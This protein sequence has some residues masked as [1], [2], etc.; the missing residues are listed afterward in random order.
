LSHREYEVEL[1]EGAQE[2]LRLRITTES[3]RV[4][5]FTVQYETTI[6]GKRIAIARFDTAHGRPHFDLL[7][8]RGRVIAKRWLPEHVGYNEALEM[9]RADLLANWRRYHRA[10]MGEPS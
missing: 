8:F 4:I 3:G 5:S 7:D 9:A 6:Q 10:S 1:D 2:W